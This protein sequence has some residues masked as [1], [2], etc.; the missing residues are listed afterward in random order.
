MERARVAQRLSGAAAWLLGDKASGEVLRTGAIVSEGF[1]IVFPRNGKRWQDR[2][3][4]K[5]PGSEALRV[6]REK[7]RS[8]SFGRARRPSPSP[9]GRPASHGH[10]SRGTEP[11]DRRTGPSRPARSRRRT[12]TPLYLLATCGW[13]PN[14]CFGWIRAQRALVSR[15]S[16]PTCPAGRWPAS[17]VGTRWRRCARR[18]T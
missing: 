2:V 17:E 15:R 14:R 11:R 10:A 8:R 13:T 16:W 7:T 1:F 5:V 4:L 12:G 6:K 9:A 3:K 18:L